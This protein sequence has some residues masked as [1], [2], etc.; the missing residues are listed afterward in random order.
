MRKSYKYKRHR[1]SEN[2]QARLAIEQSDKQSIRLAV[3]NIIS[4]AKARAEKAGF[5]H[6]QSQRVFIDAGA[7]VFSSQQSP[8]V[9]R[10]KAW[11]RHDR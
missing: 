11:M 1:P 7:R 8:G 5:R 10:S 4:R 3:H 6:V 9:V 2:T